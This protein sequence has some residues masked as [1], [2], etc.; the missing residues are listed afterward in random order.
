MKKQQVNDKK[1][2][3]SWKNRLFIFEFLAYTQF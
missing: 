1:Y 2:V 3:D